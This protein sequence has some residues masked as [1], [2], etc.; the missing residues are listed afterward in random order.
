MEVFMRSLL[1]A[2]FPL[3]AAIGSR[4]QVLSPR[5]KSEWRVRYR[6][7]TIL[8]TWVPYR[9]MAVRCLWLPGD[10]LLSFPPEVQRWERPEMK[11]KKLVAEAGAERHLADLQTELL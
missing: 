6:R 8:L 4:R 10:D 2:G 9:G 1:Y 7:C 5:R 3:H 11:K